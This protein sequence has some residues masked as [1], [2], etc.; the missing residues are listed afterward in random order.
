[1]TSVI[2]LI[3]PLESHEE[4]DHHSVTVTTRW[5][6]CQGTRW[7]STFLDT[8]LLFQKNV[9]LPMDSKFG[10]FGTHSLKRLSECKDSPLPPLM[11][12]NHNAEL[13]EG[14]ARLL[15]GR[16]SSNQAR[17]LVVFISIIIIAIIVFFIM[18]IIFTVTLSRAC[19]WIEREDLPPR[20]ETSRPATGP[21]ARV[22]G[23]LPPGWEEESS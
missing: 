11:R 3:S 19:W 16:V 8:H 7:S 6:Q 5:V 21:P 18:Y 10:P 1:M 13:S 15:S 23:H 17:C 9:P 4:G 14:W 20:Q 2:D 12:K 22:A